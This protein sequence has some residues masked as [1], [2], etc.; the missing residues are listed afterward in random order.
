M[1][2]TYFIIIL[3]LLSLSTV[4]ALSVVHS[5]N[6]ASF[7]SFSGNL[8]NL[9]EMQDVNIPTPA[10]GEVLTYH[11]ASSLWISQILPNG[12]SWAAATNGTLFTQLLWDI[13]YTAN[14]DAWLN[15]TNL[16][17]YESTNPFVFYNVTTLPA[18]Q[19]TLWNANYSTFLTHISWTE[20]T[21]GTLLSQEDWNINYTSNNNAWLNTTNLTYSAY[22]SSGLIQDWNATGYIVNWNGTGYIKNWTVDI[23]SANT[24]LYNWIVAQEY[25]SG[26]ITWENAINGTLFSQADWNTNYTANDA[27]WRLDTDT[28][29]ANYSSYLTIRDYALNGTGITWGEAINGTLLSQEDWNTNYTANNDPWLNRTNLS[30]V[31]Y[32]GATQ[33]TDLGIY[34]LTTK[35]TGF[36]S[37]IVASLN[38]SFGVDLSVGQ[39]LFVYYNSY[40][41]G[42]LFP[43]TTLSSDIGSGA[44]R[45]QWLYVQNISSDYIDNAYDID[46]ANL[47]ASGNITAAGYFLGNGSQLTDIDI[48]ETDPFWNSNWTN[49]STTHAYALNGSELWSANYSTFL[50]H[51]TWANIINGTLLSQT[52]WDTNYTANDAAWRNTTNLTYDGYNSTGLIRNWNATG[53][54][55]DWN[56]TG[57]I[58]NW[59]L[60][61]IIE[62][63]PFWTANQTLYNATWNNRTNVSYYLATNPDGYISDFNEVDPYW[64]ANQSSYFTSANTIL[65][66]NAND[67][68]VNTTMANYVLSTNATMRDYVNSL[69]HDGITWAIAINGTLLSQ[70]DWNT[71]YTANDAAWR[72][73]TDTFQANYSPFLTHIGWAEAINGTL[74]LASSLSDYFTIA[75]WDANYTANN[76]LWLNNTGILWSEAI[77]GTLADN[78]TMSDYVDSKLTTFYY[79]AT[80]SQMIEGTIDA[81]DLNDTMH[82]DGK[83]DGVTLN[84]SEGVGSPGLDF[85]FNYTSITDFNNGV[86]R[87][88]TSTLA[89]EYPII[90]IWN[91][92]GFWEDYPALAESST[93][94]TTTQQIFDSSEHIIGGVEQVR[95]Y[96]ASNGNTNNH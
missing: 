96:K 13:N 47:N 68:T 92:D 36:F 6:E 55:A 73:D 42:D 64:T 94:A 46:T 39:N 57:F 43:M 34:N 25:T 9:S 81:G 37:A 23:Y 65:Y 82:T 40:F 5:S 28:F 33:N 24:S 2:L 26:G 89:G 70:E 44:K 54:I 61:A 49:F 85:R 80:Q 18:S 71:N 11:G 50:T 53:D 59:S 16:S 52:D 66:I 29:Q 38:G 67:T 74:A 62:S 48:T 69:N 19:E 20:V 72:L 12:I 60:V 86:L 93:F 32:N 8:T 91:D 4:S 51:T 63:D 35:G 3:L 79:N 17:Y 22:N 83:Y 84:I 90:Q 27:V 7:F 88:R 31:P 56:S 45:W 58:A 14:N 41:N 78:S 76:A 21:N 87:Y 30:Y 77:N 95:F 15:T 1:K 75:N 10:D